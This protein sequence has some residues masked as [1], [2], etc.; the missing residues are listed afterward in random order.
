MNV[1]ILF[2]VD[3]AQQ[4]GKYGSGDRISS[5]CRGEERTSRPFSIVNRRSPNVFSGVPS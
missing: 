4:G 2:V 3:G 1:N 5:T